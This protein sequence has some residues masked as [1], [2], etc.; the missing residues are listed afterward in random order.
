MASKSLFF[1][2]I[3]LFLPL[4]NNEVDDF[5]SRQSSLRDYLGHF[6]SKVIAHAILAPPFEFESDDFLISR[7]LSILVTFSNTLKILFN[8]RNN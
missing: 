8:V 4:Q 3:G 7:N 1:K 6:C 5:A 2:V